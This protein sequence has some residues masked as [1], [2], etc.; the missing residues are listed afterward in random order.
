MAYNNN[1]VVLCCLAAPRFPNTN[2]QL[3]LTKNIN[4]EHCTCSNLHQLVPLYYLTPSPFLCFTDF[5]GFFQYIHNYSTIYLDISVLIYL[6]ECLYLFNNLTP[7]FSLFFFKGITG[8]RIT[9]NIMKIN[10]EQLINY[11]VDVL[12]YGE[13]EARKISTVYG[14]SYLTEEQ[15]NNCITFDSIHK[16]PF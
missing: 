15:K 4:F 14:T 16:T 1:K 2:L 9:T 11:L 3:S 6:F 13:D 7:T 8:G 12:G 10:K 5:L